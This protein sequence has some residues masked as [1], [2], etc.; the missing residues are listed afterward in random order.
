MTAYDDGVVA[1]LAPVAWLAPDSAN[2][3]F[4]DLSGNGWHAAKGAGT[5]TYAATGPTVNG[6]EQPAAQT[7]GS[8]YYTTSASIDQASIANGV[9]QALWVLLSGASSAAADIF[10]RQAGSSDRA[11][12]IRHAS[13]GQ[14]LAN[15]Y[16]AGGTLIGSAAGADIDDAF[17]LVI[18]WW[19][20]S[21]QSAYVQVDDGTPVSAV[22]AAANIDDSVATGL[23]LFGLS[24]GT[25]LVRSG[26]RIA[27]AGYWP[28]VLT[29]DERALLLS[30]EFTP[31]QVAHPVSDVTATSWAT[32]P[33]WSKIDDDPAS[34]DGVVITATAA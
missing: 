30:G 13:N 20:P 5:A 27:R 3:R 34:P 31:P 6:E 26:S 4:E 24:N 29:S 19:E 25:S 14:P 32:S 9:C 23:A 11:L 16:T 1:T 22:T 7:D 33:L 10:T 28:R 2:D 8:L 12:N 15:A 21:D 17:H 18:G